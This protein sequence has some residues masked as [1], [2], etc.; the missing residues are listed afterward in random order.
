MRIAICDDDKVFS[1]LLKN[2]IYEYSEQHNLEAVVDLFCNGFNLI[3]CKTRFDIII[4]DYE[5]NEINGLETAKSLRLGTNK[6]TCIIF[7][8]SHPEIA[9]PAYEVDTFRFVLKSTDFDSLNK[10]INS[11]LKTKSHNYNIPVRSKNE[12]VIINTEKIMYVE[13]QNKN[14][15]IHLDNNNIIKTNSSLTAFCN[16]LPH[17]HF[18]KIHKAFVVN[19]DYISRREKNNL[20]LNNCTISL[21]ISRNYMQSYKNSYYNY[22]KDR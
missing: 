14:I 16:E 2:N 5:M 6:S 15:F 19:F 12:T 3:D 9:I 1:N 7:L 21:P 20:L 22:L 17:T 8:T 11:Y 13:A 4:L 18:F 10:A